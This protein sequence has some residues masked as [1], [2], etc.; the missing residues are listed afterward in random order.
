[1]NKYKV[2]IVISAHEN[3]YRVY[4]ASSKEDAL[5]QAKLDFPEKT[6]TLDYEEIN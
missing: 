1:M 6:V 3:R 4:E 2:K 5:N